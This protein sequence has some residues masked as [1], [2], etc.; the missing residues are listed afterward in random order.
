[1]DQLAREVFQEQN[2]V[3]T[4]PTSYIPYLQE[5]LTQFKGMVLHKPNEIPLRTNE[6][7]GAVQD[8]INYLR[9][10]KPLHPYQWDD[11][12]TRAASDHAN[13]IGPKGISNHTG[14]DGSSMS[15][16]LE[17]YGDWM[18]KIG[19]NIDFGSKTARDI[20]LSLIIDDGVDN[21]GHRKNVLSPDFQKTGVACQKH[22][23]WEICTVLDYAS[24]YTFKGGKLSGT[25]ITDNT[26]KFTSGSTFG[27]PQYTNY[28][29]SS[30]AP[31]QTTTTYSTSPYTSSS[32]SYTQPTSTYTQAPSSLPV[33][34]DLLA[35]EVFQEQNRVRQNP[36]SY[37]PYLEEHLK[38]FQGMVLKKPGEIPLRTHEGPGAVQDCINFLRVQK[39]LHALEWDDNMTRACRD[40]ANDIGPK[41]LC[42]HTG[43]DGSSMSSRLERYGDWNG[44]IGENCDFG[45]SS[46][47]DVIISLI[48]DDGV[49]NRGH[50][51]NL[52]SPD[53]RKVGIACANHV[54]YKT[55]VVI[56]Y[57]S[58]YGPKG[59]FNQGSYT[60]SFPSST[61]SGSYVPTSSYNTYTSQNPY[62]NSTT[63][64]K[65]QT[66]ASQNIND[67]FIQEQLRKHN[68]DTNTF[69]SS[70][71][72]QNYVDPEKPPNTIETSIQKNITIINGRRNVTE[73]RTYKLADGSQ[74]ITE[75][76]YQE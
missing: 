44:K 7:P 5:M 33:N 50:R 48:V 8:C 36:T 56:D 71:S 22:A 41:N 6:G 17:R 65:T 54:D 20:V 57:A 39:P 15:N 74:K 68:I 55:C 62:N 51:N 43:S 75:R 13:D 45:N 53:F 72:S 9:S 1:M 28:T 29:T 11:N 42:G 16:R 47:R 52:F 61:V 63:T 38:L 14:S 49:S 59:S 32:V 25:L 12:M 60:T 73:T 27:Q 23:Q 40:H 3:R 19:E 66:Y 70:G 37:I 58:Q 76:T 67:P 2:R 64:T 10:L 69:G 4:N 30:Y 21:R 18:G 35:R 34:H 26:P 31:G 46:A 24:E